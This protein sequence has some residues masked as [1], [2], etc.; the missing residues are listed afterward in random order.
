MNE[1]VKE[2][3]VTSGGPPL[4]KQYD[5]FISYRH[6]QEGE[7]IDL[8]LGI[9]YWF[10]TKGIRCFLDV[11]ELGSGR[12]KEKL[13]EHIEGSKYFLVLLA[14]DVSKSSWVSAEID[15]ACDK[16]ESKRIIP[17][18]IDK[19]Y[20]ENPSLSRLEGLQGFSVYRKKFDSSLRDIVEKGMQEFKELLNSHEHGVDR[21]LSSIRWYKRND[22]QIKADEKERIYGAAEEFRM[23]KVL[24]DDLINQVEEEWKKEQQFKKVYILPRYK[25]GNRIDLEEH[26]DLQE[27]ADQHDISQDRLNELILAVNAEEAG[28]R[29]WL[30]VI[31]TVCVV[32]LAASIWLVAWWYG[33]GIGAAEVN[34]R[35]AAKIERLEAKVLTLESEKAKLTKELEK[36]RRQK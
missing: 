3:M 7:G 33:R 13:F 34:G 12:Y 2:N 19:E 30:W 11:V 28:K 25:R 10:R 24:C 5:V 22:G 20:E 6:G 1:S 8:A 17:V 31:S 9:Y 16:L 32:C 29:R 4:K 36:V 27:L 14:D 23:S 18:S 35:S 15:C 21:L 26:G